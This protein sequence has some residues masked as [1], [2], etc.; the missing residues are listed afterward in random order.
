MNLVDI[1]FQPYVIIIFISI[2]ITII[3]YFII[4]KE[5]VEENN[6]KNMAKKLLIIFVSSFIILIILKLTI[7]YMNKNN[8]F[9]KGGE[10]NTSDRLTL[11]SDDIDIGLIDTN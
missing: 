3:S 5:K 7:N 1:F 6:K 8:F 10:I 2:I 4:S 9:Q 11:E